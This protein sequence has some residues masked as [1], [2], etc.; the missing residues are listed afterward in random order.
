MLVF[1]CLQY[2]QCARYSFFSLFSRCWSR[3][4]RLLSSTRV[5]DQRFVDMCRLAAAP[6]F[7]FFFAAVRLTTDEK[8]Q[9]H[10]HHMFDRRQCAK[11]NFNA[12]T[13][14]VGSVIF[15]L[16]DFHMLA[17][18]AHIFLSVCRPFS[19]HIVDAIFFLLVCVVAFFFLSF[20]L[21]IFFSRWMMA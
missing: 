8:W 5:F 11:D 2:V 18:C 21:P 7:F 12:K 17:Q 10:L 1:I 16:I 4:Q 13:K 15:T 19:H 3:C 20:L 6:I 9:T 14:R